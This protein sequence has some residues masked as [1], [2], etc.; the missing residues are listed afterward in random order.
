MAASKKDEIPFRFGLEDPEQRSESERASRG[1]QSNNSDR[2]DAVNQTLGRTIL[3]LLRQMGGSATVFAILEQLPA[4]RIEEILPAATWLETGG[5][6]QVSSRPRT[7]D[8]KLELTDRAKQM[9]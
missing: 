9:F 1:A 3:G 6:V 5:F 8:W 7:G 2:S 4:F